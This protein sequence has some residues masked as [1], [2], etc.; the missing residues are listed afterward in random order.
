MLTESFTSPLAGEVG[1]KGRVGRF[2]PGNSPDGSS[3]FMGRWRVAPEG[4]WGR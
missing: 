2:D 4:L 3:P 1:L